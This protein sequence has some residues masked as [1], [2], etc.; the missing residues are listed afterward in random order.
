MKS[1]AGRPGTGPS[2]AVSGRPAN[3][4]RVGLAALLI[5]GGGLVF[6]GLFRARGHQVPVLV[7]ARDVAAGQSLTAKDVVVAEVAAT[8][9]AT[10]PAKDRTHLNGVVAKVGLTKGALL[11]PQQF[12]SALPLPLDEALV[13]LAFPEV[14]V[15]R[16][17]RSDDRVRLV[18]GDRVVDAKVTDIRAGMASTGTV[19]VTFQLKQDAARLVAVGKDVRLL[20]VG[21]A[22]ESSVLQ[23][24][25]VGVTNGVAGGAPGASGVSV[26]GASG[27]VLGGVSAP[28]TSG[29]VAGG[30]PSTSGNP[31]GG[32]S[33]SGA[34][35]NPIGGAVVP[36]DAGSRPVLA[37]VGSGGG[38]K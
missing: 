37:A 25:A 35:G 20:V 2:R 6:L 32:V 5:V 19:S 7:M 28:S 12:G 14:A 11:A 23:A 38:S 3:P 24:E 26:S 16:S 36:S 1:S 31:I 10:V 27:G 18:V 9:V 8:G 29:G 22:P 34:S 13:A 21:G 30:A 15:P 4:A 17:M 33:A